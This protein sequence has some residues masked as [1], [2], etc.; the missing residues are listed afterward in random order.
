MTPAS[1]GAVRL[2]MWASFL[3]AIAASG[4]IVIASSYSAFNTSTPNPSPTT[5]SS[6]VTTSNPPR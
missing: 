2:R 6:T 1:P 5:P 3:V 4:L